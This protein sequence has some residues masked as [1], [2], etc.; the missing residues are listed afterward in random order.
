[1]PSRLHRSYPN[2]FTVPLTLPFRSMRTEITAAAST[3]AAFFVSASGNGKS[4]K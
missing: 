4:T 1:V 3:D 2:R